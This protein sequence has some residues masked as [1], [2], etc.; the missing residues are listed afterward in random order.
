M[1][2]SAVAFRISNIFNMTYLKKAVKTAFI[3]GACG[4]GLCA[5]I[6]K[7]GLPIRMAE[8][9]QSIST[10]PLPVTRAYSVLTARQLK[11]LYEAIAADVASAG[12][13]EKILDVGTGLGYLPVELA[14]VDSD[15]CL[16]G[17]DDSSNLIRL[18]SAG[19][20][21]HSDGCIEFMAGDYDNLPFPG[22]YFDMAVSVNVLHHW[23]SPVSVLEEVFHVLLPGA[24]FWIYDYRNDVPDEVWNTAY[25]SLPAHLKAMLL[26]GPEAS[27]RT[28]YSDDEIRS[29][30]RQTRFEEVEFA[31][32][33]FPLFGKDAPVFNR[34]KL[35]KPEHVSE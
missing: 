2:V 33:T 17:V 30:I 5:L 19:Q 25:A 22:R 21:V 34:I 26:F 20:T 13:F 28:A 24:Q 18:A 4:I 35:I 7:L 14:K 32:V 16:F 1:N 9:G 31:K 23:K 27:S 12:H 11:P 3:T 6:R 15:S 10:R 8:K 29:F